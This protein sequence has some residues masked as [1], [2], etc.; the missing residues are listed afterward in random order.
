M[1]DLTT[2]ISISL[3]PGLL[4]AFDRVSRQSGYGDRS[5]ALQ[6]AMRGFISDFETG[7]KGGSVVG[8]IVMVYN[9]E[10]KGTDEAITETSHHHRQSILSSLHAH[11]D[12]AHCLCALLVRGRVLDI[13][14]LEGELKR[15]KG[16]MQVKSSYLKTESI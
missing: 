12:E 3:P 15:E 9:H 10:T 5:K 7:V 13:A 2:R 6:A 14:S 11:I 8:S 1:T 4:E 16:I